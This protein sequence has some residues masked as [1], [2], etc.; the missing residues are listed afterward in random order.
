M[1]MKILITLL[2]LIPFLATA[3]TKYN[4]ESRKLFNKAEKEYKDGN[5][6]IAL[7]LFEECVKADSR[8][9]EG[10]LNISSI[11]YSKN[12]MGEAL[13]NAKKAYANN[14]FEPAI[15]SQLGKSYY[16]AMMYDSS[17]YYL[18]KAMD[19]G[20]KDE[21]IY[22]YIG[23]ALFE[24]DEF[25]TA[26]EFLT[27]A[28]TLNDKNPVSYN[29]RG[30]IYFKQGEWDKAELDFEKALEL[31]PKSI[32]LYVNLANCE[33][34]NEKPE[35]ALK[36]INTGIENADNSGKTQLY[37]LLGNYYHRSGNYDLALENYDR[38]HE[39]DRNDPHVL[40][41]QAAVFLDKDDYESAISKCNSALEIDPEMMEAYF[42][43]GIANE[44]LRKVEQACSDWEQAFI[45]GSEKAEEYL[46]SPTCN[47]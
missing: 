9:A 32:A 35:E 39:F 23:K 3:Q 24:L 15:Y 42:N 37:L 6:T 44:M 10:Y 40:N 5:I 4:S 30:K 41:N 26:N 43:R 25:T 12:Q 14:K 36:H 20:K 38:A 22:I 8:H 7:G 47:E 13:V 29:S 18:Q 27:K 2:L 45:L 21:F 33:L 34:E 31:N 28:I 16:Q 19:M 17:A 1:G 11:L 46:N